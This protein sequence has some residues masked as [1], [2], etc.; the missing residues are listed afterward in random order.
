MSM[1]E[2]R[3]YDLV[4]PRFLA[5]LYPA[6][7]YE[8][9]SLQAQIGNETFT[10]KGMVLLEKGWKEVYDTMEEEALQSIPSLEKG[11]KLLV[12]QLTITE[13][14]TKPPA[15]F[16]SEERRVGTESRYRSSRS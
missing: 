5:V 10:A 16:R 13:G 14:K 7:E 8:Q 11:M 2:R 1:E 15:Y 4:V 6:A 9:T 12:R 3:I